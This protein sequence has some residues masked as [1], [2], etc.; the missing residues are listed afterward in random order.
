MEKLVTCEMCGNESE[1]PL[2]V[3]YQGQTYTFDSFECAIEAIAPHC[4]ICSCPIPGHG[5]EQDGDVFCSAYCAN[6]SGAEDLDERYSAVL[7][8]RLQ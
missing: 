2:V 4:K 8:G 3:T 5:F 6:A 1:K 7:E